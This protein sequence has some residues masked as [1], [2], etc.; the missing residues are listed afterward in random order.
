MAHW[1]ATRGASAPRVVE[2]GAVANGG[3]Q[4]VGWRSEASSAA[5]RV[6][7]AT[8]QGLRRQ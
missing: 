8:A 4:H 2:H 6:A 3:R 5:C 7:A 1:A